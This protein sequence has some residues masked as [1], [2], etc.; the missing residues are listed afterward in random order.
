MQTVSGSSTQR[1]PASINRSNA[2]KPAKRGKRV[3]AAIGTAAVYLVLIVACII[4]LYPLLWV[5]SCSFKSTAGLVG[6]R[7]IPE[8]PTLDNYRQI[9]NDSNVNFPLWFANTIKVS[10]ISSLLALIL[11]T[12]A[13]YAFSRMRFAGRRQTL[14]AFMISQMFP[15][16]MAIVALFTLLGWMGLVDTHAGLIAIHAGG[17]VPFS[18]WLLK[19]YFD[20][21]PRDMEESAQ[22]DGAT[23]FQAF[24]KILLPLARPILYVVGII[25]FIGPYADY[26]MSTVVLTSGSKWTVAMGMR[27]LTVTQFA[28]NW[29]VFSAVSVLT[30]APIIAM[31]LSAERYIVSGLTAGAVK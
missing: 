17:S 7:L 31:F 28:T 11:T 29:T 12:P 27:S 16:I 13:A 22:I 21:I 20:S 2:T 14:I 18:I 23:R 3:G 4:V 10:T 25:N 15:S 6:T 5:L 1:E 26:L 30:A 9:F 8:N 19:G 24:T